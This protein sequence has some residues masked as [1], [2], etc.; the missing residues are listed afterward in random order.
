[1]GPWIVLGALCVM[2]LGIALGSL[3]DARDRVLRDQLVQRWPV[4]YAEPAPA[5]D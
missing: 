1:M 2:G 4:R 5:E 3:L